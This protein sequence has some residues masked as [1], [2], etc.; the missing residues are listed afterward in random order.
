MP[1]RSHKRYTL[2][3]AAFKN[4]ARYTW[5]NLAKRHDLNMRWPEIAITNELVYRLAKAN[6]PHVQIYEAIDEKIHGHDI[7]LYIEVLPKKYVLLCLQAKV[8]YAK[9]YTRYHAIDHKVKDP[10]SGLKIYQWELLSQNPADRIPFYLF[11]NGFNAARYAVKV[12][13]VKRIMPSLSVKGCSVM[14]L[15]DFKE[16]FL[17]K[18]WQL[19]GHKRDIHYVSVND[20]GT[21]T[22]PDALPWHHLF[23]IEHWLTEAVKANGGQ[24][25]KTHSG[26]GESLID[27]KLYRKLLPVPKPGTDQPEF[28]DFPNDDDQVNY[29]IPAAFKVMVAMSDEEIS[30][31][32]R[33]KL[34]LL[35]TD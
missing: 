25:I 24:K 9:P 21:R 18:S 4:L 5:R 27:D 12:K 19:K 8:M 32:R 35:I 26:A 16:R 6:L 31:S 15:G 22:P 30:E 13:P 10:V 3:A 11:Y 28:D 2:A 20:S 29:I 14:F 34:E 23:D 33:R 1:P 17:T 7:D